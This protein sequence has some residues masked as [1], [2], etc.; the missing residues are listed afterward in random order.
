MLVACRSSG[1]IISVASVTCSARRYQHGGH[2]VDVWISSSTMWKW[3]CVGKKMDDVFLCACVRVCAVDVTVI[4]DQYSPLATDL[5][6]SSLWAQPSGQRRNTHWHTHTNYYTVPHIQILIRTSTEMSQK[7]VLARHDKTATHAALS[8]I[9]I[10]WK[11]THA[12]CI[13]TH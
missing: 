4:S 11:F 9:G 13:C 5:R 7:H 6:S 8:H 12:L 2:T 10:V 1:Q 3:R